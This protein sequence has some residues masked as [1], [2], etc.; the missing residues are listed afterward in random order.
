MISSFTSPDSIRNNTEIVSM[1][2]LG[3]D[4]FNGV[5]MNLFFFPSPFVVALR[6]NVGGS[7]LVALSPLGMIEVLPFL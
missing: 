7:N 6:G 1:P 2:G 5:I 4:P 3:L